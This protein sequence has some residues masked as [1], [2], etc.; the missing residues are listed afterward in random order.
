V[1]TVR[2]ALD[3]NCAPRLVGALTALYGHKGFQFLHLE[4]L[5]AGRT[6]DEIWADA[7]KR[8]GGHVVI[9]GDTRI[10]Y[11]PHQAIAFIDNGFL[12]FF[13]DPCFCQMPAHAR[14]ATFVY[15]WPAIE[16][17]IAEAPP[18][19]CWRIPC[20]FSKGDGELKLSGEPLW[21]LA[22]PDEILDKARAQ[23]L[24]ARAVR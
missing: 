7:Y 4:T 1:S 8:T 10:A 5:V 19:T 24:A 9:S 21:P 2:V 15:A 11:R 20:S 12:S 3:F 22:I 14:S 18:G 23:R 16:R 13:P 17:K 6:D